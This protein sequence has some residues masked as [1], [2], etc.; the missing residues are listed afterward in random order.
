MDLAQK[1]H[2]K[3]YGI[4]YWILTHDINVEWLLNFRGGSFML[5][6]NPSILKECRV[7]GVTAEVI[8]DDAVLATYT[9]IDANNMEIVL[10]EKTP[11]IAIYTPPNRQPWD[12]AVTLALTYAEVDY[13]TLWDEEVFLGHLDKYDWLHLHHEDFTGQYGKF[14]R[15]YHNAPWYVQQQEEFEAMA[16]RLGFPTV[17]EEKK[18]VALKIKNYVGQGGFLFAMCSATDSYDIALAAEEVD[19]VESVF[20]GTP[21]DLKSQQKLDFTRS[22]AFHEFE[23]ITDPFIYEFSNIDIPSSD[24]PITRGAEADYFTLFEFSAKYDPVPAML[25]QNHVAVIKGFMGQTTGFR[26]STIKQHILIMGEVEEEEQVKYIHGNFGRGTFTF[27]GG[28]DPEDYQHFV[29]DPPTDLSLH[30]NSP[31]YRLILNNVLFPA[32]RKKERKT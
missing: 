4:A 12:D 15:N 30:R 29:G 19:I 20:D 1:D 27:L 22:F 25:T 6:H 14:Y 31:G 26:R 16:Q 5:E 10:L 21:A 23:I 3:A 11:K 18:A 24:R 17:S 8:S 7:R 2:L 13:E 9:K 32:A 28:H